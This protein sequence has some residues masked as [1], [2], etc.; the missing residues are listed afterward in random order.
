MTGATG[1]QGPQGSIGAQGDPGEDGYPGPQG[2]TGVTGATG[3]GGATG[4]TGSAGATGATGSA[5]ATGATGSAGATGVTGATGPGGVAQT[6][7]TKSADQT[8]TNNA[9]PQADSELTAVL[10]ANTTYRVELLLAFSGNNATGDYRCQFAPG[11]AVWTSSNGFHNSYSAAD[12]SQLVAS[13]GSA[14]QWPAA[15]ALFGTDALDTIRTAYL[16]FIVRVG[17]TGGTMTFKFANSAASAGRTSTTR[18]GT[19]LIV[20]PLT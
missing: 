17:I 13:L 9:T 8:V 15:D 20:T 10:S 4:P 3:T 11:L 5:G 16:Q 18:A 6:V 19:K 1:A 12:A 2:T 7:V 14:T